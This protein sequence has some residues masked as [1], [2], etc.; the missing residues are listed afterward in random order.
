MTVC[1]LLKQIT[2]KDKKQIVLS[3]FVATRKTAHWRCITVDK[4][5]V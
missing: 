1:E 2:N 4:S 3:V 5:A